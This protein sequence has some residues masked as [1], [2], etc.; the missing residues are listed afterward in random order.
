MYKGPDIPLR[1]A[2]LFRGTGD[3]LN[4][5]DY[6]NHELQIGPFDYKAWPNADKYYLLPGNKNHKILNKNRFEML[7]SANTSQL[8]R[9]SKN[10]ISRMEPKQQLKL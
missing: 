3:C 7:L 2:R 1:T 8:L 6:Q 10:Q 4:I 5:Y 9:L